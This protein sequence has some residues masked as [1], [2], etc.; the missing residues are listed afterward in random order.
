VPDAVPVA[1]AGD[2]LCARCEVVRASCSWCGVPAAAGG[3]ATTKAAAGMT[4]EA[5]RSTLVPLPDR[6]KGVMRWVLVTAI[7]RA[8]GVCC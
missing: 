8:L 7:S 2:G 5:A 6:V 3:G 4:T 1:A